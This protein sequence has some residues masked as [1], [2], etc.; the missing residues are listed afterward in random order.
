MELPAS[1]RRLADALNAH[2]PK[3]VAA[4]FTTEYHC[5]MPLHPERSLTGNAQVAQ[6]Y[7]A[8]FDRVPDLRA[9]VLRWTSDGDRSWSEWEMAGT[10][11]DNSPVRMCGVVIAD[12]PEGGPIARTR[13]YIEPVTQPLT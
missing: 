7:S 3:Q 11:P 6:N 9:E 4:A 8:I 5:E 13:L 12:S 2:D 1:L 10:G